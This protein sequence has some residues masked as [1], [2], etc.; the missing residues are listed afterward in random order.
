MT[1]MVKINPQTHAKLQQL[2]RADNRSMGEVVSELVDR[3]ERERFWTG[4]EEDLARL[5]TDPVARQGYQDEIALW[6][7]LAGDGLEHEGPYYTPEEEE[8][9]RGKA[10]VART[11]GG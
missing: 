1:A 2:A 4:V 10:A 11:P 7:Q 5:K 8:E 3:Y 6:D 9:I